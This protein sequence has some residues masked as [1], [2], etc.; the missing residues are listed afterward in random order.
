MRR[1][2]SV[3]LILYI[4]MKKLQKLPLERIYS[5]LPTEIKQ[6]RKIIS[7]R[8]G[9]GVAI[10]IDSSLLRHLKLAT[11]PYLLE[12]YRMGLVLRGKLH[13]YINLREYVIEE[14]SI[15]FVTPGTI[16]EP[17]DVSDD[18]LMQGVGL[19]ADKFLLAHGGKLPKLF[20]GQISDGRILTSMTDREMISRIMCL[21]HDLLER[22]EPFEDVVLHMVAT[23]SYYYDQLFHD[24][25][26]MPTPTHTGEIFNRFLRLVN[27]YGCREHQLSFYA[28]KLCITSRYLG[29]VVLSTSGIGAKEW[30]DRA[31]ISTAKVLLRHSD[32]Q[33]TEVANELNFPNVSFFCKYFKRLTGVTPQQYRTN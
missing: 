6:N 31:I 26:S 14:G 27:L 13:G 8:G 22:E 1:I 18:F 11:S 16:V 12:D 23:L 25:T 32:K 24:R 7:F 3:T 2:L 33:T 28:D 15:V 10:G 20:N 17:I 30:I 9:I 19:P 29:T 21:L 4:T 5:I